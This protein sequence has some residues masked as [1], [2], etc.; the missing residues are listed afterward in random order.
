ME[1]RTKNDFSLQ[2]YYSTVLRLQVSVKLEIHAGMASLG[3]EDGTTR[4][5]TRDAVTATSVGAAHRVTPYDTPKSVSECTSNKTQPKIFHHTVSSAMTS[6]TVWHW[7]KKGLE[8]VQWLRYMPSNDNQPKSPPTVQST[9]PISNK[10]EQQYLYIVPWYLRWTLEC[11]YCS[12]NI[13]FPTNQ[14]FFHY[15][16]Y[17]SHPPESVVVR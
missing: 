16:Q 17:T 2:Y 5:A 6:F 7:R 13:R 8:E 14:S 4:H 11:L 10:N 15:I 3:L 12:C 1:L 9:F